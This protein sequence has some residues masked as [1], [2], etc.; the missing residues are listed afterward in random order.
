MDLGLAG[1]RAL[2]A[3][4]SSGLGLGCAQALAA[5]GATVA[6]DPAHMGL[7]GLLIVSVSVLSALFPAWKAS[8]VEP[9]EALISL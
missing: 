9:S 3:G 8:S 5:E 6:F 4:A 7:T 2:I 1:K